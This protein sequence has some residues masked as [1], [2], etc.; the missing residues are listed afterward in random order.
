MKMRWTT[1]V[2]LFTAVGV[3]AQAQEYEITEVADDLYRAATSSHRTVFLVTEEGIILADP[4]NAD[5]ATWLR[6]ELDER[7]GLPVRYVLYSH[8]HWDHASGGAAF[9]DTATYVAH[10]GMAAALAAPLPSNAAFQDANGNGLLERSE[11]TGGYAA[12]FD[13]FNTNGDGALSGAEINVDIH[14][15]DLLYSD[16]MV[17]RLGGQT[18]EL[19]HAN[20][21]HSDDTTVLYF[22]EQRV[23]FAVDYINVRRLPGGLDPYPFDDYVSAVGT[24]FELDIDIVVPGHGN[25]GQREHL[26]EYMGFL[27]DLE[28]AVSAAIADGQSLQQAQQSV[29]LSEYADW[30]LFDERRENLIAGAYRILTMP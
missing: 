17:V 21:A 18:V 3:S 5:F 7:F 28:A 20:P 24:M 10:E 19:V 30:L 4:I 29:R 2:W 25:V 14:P 9:A 22:P 11:A 12:N 26:G 16:R 1:F 8:H 15:P 13:R 6:S 27:R 23:G